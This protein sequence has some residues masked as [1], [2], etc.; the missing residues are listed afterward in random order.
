[1]SAPLVT[2]EVHRSKGFPGLSIVGLPETEVRESRY[3]IRSAFLNMGFEFPRSRLTINLAPA[4]LPKEGSRFDLPIA[5]GVLAA[6]SQ[7]PIDRLMEYEFVGELAL[8]GELRPVQG[9]LPM[10]MSVHQAGR[11][12]ILP[13]ANASE[14]GLVRQAKV[15]FAGHLLEVCEYLQN[16]RDLPVCSPME[17]PQETEPML[18]LSD[19]Y[20]QP[21]ARRALEVA[22]AGRHS[23]IV[24]GPPGTGKTML[25]SR[26]PG[27][28]PDLTEQEAVEVA[29]IASVSK[30]GFDMVRWQSV[31]FRAPHHSSSAVALVGGGRPLH[32]GEISLAHHGVLFLDELPEFSRHALESLREPLE[33]GKITVS[34]AAARAIFPAQFHFVAAMNPCPCGYV[35]SPYHDCRCTSEQIQRYLAKLSGPLLDRID[36]QITV[37]ALPPGTLPLVPEREESSRQVKTRVIAARQQQLA[38]QGKLNH[39]LTPGDL[40]KFCKL[41]NQSRQLLTEI[42]QKFNLSMRA[43]HRILKVAR[44]IADLMEDENILNHHLGEALTYRCLDR[45]K[46]TQY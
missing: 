35:G 31:P 32:P 41:D 11:S 29:A 14:A 46:N 21:H 39:Q 38:R 2:I 36:I 15:F 30:E 4:D 44:T 27:I 45:L 18:D 33:A 13:Q 3:R 22:A 10:V 42:V 7:L 26:L 37:S 20:G 19:V 8:S 6:S 25:A 34:R 1:M 28:L 16:K 43:Y 9:I 23:L 17:K 24:A 12:L 40:Q 5:L